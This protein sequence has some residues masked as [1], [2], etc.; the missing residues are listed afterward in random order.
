MRPPPGIASRALTTRFISTWSIRAGST[1][2]GSG[3][4]SSC[5]LELD[6]LADHAPE[7]RDELAYQRVEVDQAAVARLRAREGEE[8]TD[9]CGST[10]GCGAD[11]CSALDVHA[12]RKSGHEPLGVPGDHAEEVV[13]VVRDAAR[14][15]PEGLELLRLP[16]LLFELPLLADVEQVPLE[17]RLPAGSCAV[18]HGH[19]ID[20]DHPPEVGHHAVGA[21]KRLSTR[22]GAPP[23]PLAQNAA[24]VERVQAG[25]PEV[26]L[27]DGLLGR[28]LEQ[29]LDLRADVLD[30][31]VRHPCRIAGERQFLEEVAV[32]LLRVLQRAARRPGCARAG[33]RPRLPRGRT[34]PGR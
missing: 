32:A 5:E 18:E 14:E 22:I 21:A 30:A 33:G 11:R 24:A 29:P 27:C 1:S 10:V 7:Q 19:V 4:C 31:R 3:C 23:A 20:P 28:Q 17:P 6:V 2:T 26:L 34:P 16:E 25:S 13:E 12:L 15:A 8:L 9:E